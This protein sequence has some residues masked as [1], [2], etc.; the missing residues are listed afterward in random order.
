[1]INGNRSN[2]TDFFMGNRNDFDRR[3]CGVR[4]RL[5]F[6]F[7]MGS[8]E[9]IF[10]YISNL[11]LVVIRLFMKMY[12]FTSNYQLIMGQFRSFGSDLIEAK[13]AFSIE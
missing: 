9:E 3:G 1:M 2:R 4:I 11:F 5:V 12:T 7:L 6:T 13:G 8:F 10:I